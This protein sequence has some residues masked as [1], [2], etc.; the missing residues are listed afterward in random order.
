MEIKEDEIKETKNIG[1][2][3]NS[4]VKL[5]SLKGGFHIGVG[6]KQSNSRNSEIL[7]VGSHPAIVSHQISKKYNDNFEQKMEKNETEQLPS[8]FEYSHNLSSLSKNVLG[9]DIYAIKK[10]EKT[11]KNAG[12]LKNVDK[13]ELSK[14]LEKTIKEYANKN[15]LTVKKK[16]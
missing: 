14:N 7:A 11:E 4:E 2:L 15:G 3:Y 1:T 8:I 16:F 6:K 12:K 5:I 9:L 10:N 13:T